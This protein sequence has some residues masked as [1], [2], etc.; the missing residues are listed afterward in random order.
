MLVLRN[1]CFMSVCCFYYSSTRK[2]RGSVSPKRRLTFTGLHVCMSQKAEL[3]YKYLLALIET[4]RSRHV[5][6]C[7]SLS[8]DLRWEDGGLNWAGPLF[9]EV[10][11][12]IWIEKVNSVAW[13][14]E[15]TIPTELPTLIGEISANFCGYRVPRCRRDGSLRT[16]SR[17]S[18]LEPLL[19]LPSSCSIVLTRLS[20]PR[21]RPTTCQKIW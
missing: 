1:V 19:F 18:R 20:E 12:R 2:Y 13:V 14:R 8:Y 17:I 16:Y 15:R 6:Q 7:S 5:Y 11:H 21:S 4:R 9:K 10:E 3:F